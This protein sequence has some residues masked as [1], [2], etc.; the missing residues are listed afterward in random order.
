MDEASYCHRITMMVDGV[1][2]ALDTPSNLKTQY[3]AASI[4]AVFFEL[5]RGAKEKQIKHETIQGIYL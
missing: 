3:H 1:I 2:K 4:D 5:V